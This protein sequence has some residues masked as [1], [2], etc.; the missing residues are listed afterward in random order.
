[1]SQ[2]WEESEPLLTQLGAGGLP[3]AAKEYMG[4]A[5]HWTDET[6]TIVGPQHSAL[7][8]GVALAALLWVSGVRLNL[9]FINEAHWI[10]V[11]PSSR[12]RKTAIHAALRH[13]RSAGL[14]PMCEQECETEVQ[15]DGT[16]R[17]YLAEC[18]PAYVGFTLTDPAPQ[19]EP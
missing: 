5:S 14:E 4:V 16:Q 7:G 11:K 13:A 10:E 8:V 3:C 9:D 2:E 19:L 12:P 15:W 1:M 17:V 18:V 6:V